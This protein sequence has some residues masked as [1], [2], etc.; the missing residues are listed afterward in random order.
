M[1]FS[2]WSSA[3]QAADLSSPCCRDVSDPNP[4]VRCT[5]ISTLCSIPGLQEQ[6]AAALH[7]G[8]RLIPLCPQLSICSS[9]RC[10]ASFLSVLSASFLSVLN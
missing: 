10:P 7:I 6:A 3:R 8:I 5:A 9:Y 2:L 4:A 1:F